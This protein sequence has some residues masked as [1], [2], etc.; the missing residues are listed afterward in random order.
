MDPDANW[1]EQCELYKAMLDARNKTHDELISKGTRLAELV[2]AMDVWIRGG[3]FL[4]A[5]W[6]RK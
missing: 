5:A 2:E 4:P 1:Q 6:V 3:G